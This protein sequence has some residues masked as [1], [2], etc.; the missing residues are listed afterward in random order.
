[1]AEE[2]E[3]GPSV[4]RTREELRRHDERTRELA[5]DDPPETPGRDSGGGGDDEGAD[6][7]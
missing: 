7:P 3:R 4:D 5:D 1:M 6:T 2:H